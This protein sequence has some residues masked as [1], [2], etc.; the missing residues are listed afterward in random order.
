MVINHSFPA[1][2]LIKLL[3]WHRSGCGYF[4]C[5]GVPPGDDVPPNPLSDVLQ[6]Q[7]AGGGGRKTNLKPLLFALL[8]LAGRLGT[9]ISPGQGQYCSNTCCC[10]GQVFWQGGREGARVPLSFAEHWVLH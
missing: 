6:G 7:A 3:T 8:C 1:E 4:W 9:M 5:W 2:G 10:H